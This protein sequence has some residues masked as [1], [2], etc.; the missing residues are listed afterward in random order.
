MELL[1]LLADKGIIDRSKIPTIEQD[2]GGASATSLAIETALVAGG[3][4]LE[5]ILQAK[6]EYYQMPTRT[7]GDSAIPFSVL[8]YVPAESARHYRLAPI[9][10]ADGALEI[11]ITDPDNLE[12][13][14]VINFVSN[15]AGLPYKLYLLSETDF[16]RVLEHYSGLGGEVGQALSELE[17]ELVGRARGGRGGGETESATPE[18]EVITETGAAAI[19]EDAPVTKIVATI[20]RHAV[21]ENASDIHIEAMADRTRVRFRVDGALSENLTLPQKIH[22]SV[23]TRIKVLAS[24]RLDEKRKPQDGRFSARVGGKRV[25]FRVSTFPTYWGEKV[26]MRI[27]GTQSKDWTLDKLGL[28]ARNLG[29]LRNAIR[30]PYGL[31][32]ISGPTG[33]GKSTTLYSILS[34]TDTETKNVLS[35]EDPVEYTIAGVSQ[36]QV[37]PE[38]GYTFATGLRTTLRQDPNIIM[39]GEIRDKETAELAVQASLTGHLVL[40]T[41]HTNDAIGIVP[42]LLDMGVDPYLIPP[43]LI[44]GIAQRLVRTLCP[45]GGEKTPVEGSVKEMMDH[46]FADLPKEFRGEVPPLDYVYRAKPTRDCPSGTRGRTAVFEM[47]DMTSE[48]ERAILAGKSQQ[49]LYAVVRKAGMLTIKEDAIIKSA[50]NFVPFE[51]INTIGGEFDFAFDDSEMAGEEPAKETKEKPSGEVKPVASLESEVEF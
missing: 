7:L 15:K 44:L 35:L 25:D 26:E 38:I 31:I 47:F 28:S 23:V 11:G 34:E 33:S 37:R 19:T 10:V 36:S 12:A 3:I 48:L 22:A 39:V 42:R 6:G 29:L 46:Q 40:S 8:R 13:R 51:E 2:A 16:N 1:T 49:E 24:M 18:G 32:L 45:T 21:E 14:D 41:I 30:K 5:T 9:G 4:P 27:L 50:Q 20:V 43:T 17:S